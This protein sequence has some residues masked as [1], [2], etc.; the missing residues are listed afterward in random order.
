MACPLFNLWLRNPE[1]IRLRRIILPTAVLGFSVTRKHSSN[2]K[3]TLLCLWGHKNPP[4]V[5]LGK[6]LSNSKSLHPGIPHCSGTKLHLNTVS[7]SGLNR[8][9]ATYRRNMQPLIEM[10]VQSF[11]YLVKQWFK[12]WK[13]WVHEN[14]EI[15]ILIKRICWIP[16]K[17]SIEENQTMV[18]WQ[19][20][21]T[22][23]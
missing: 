3:Y 13:F 5:G 8:T 15:Q 18:V 16:A 20:D 19:F 7:D 21:D 11:P 9:M 22:L 12:R 2:W 1:I 4:F 17:T 10:Q 14:R 6:H 23:I